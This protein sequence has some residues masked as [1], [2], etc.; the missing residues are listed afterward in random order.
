MRDVRDGEF[1]L[2]LS[3]PTSTVSVR[4]TILSLTAFKYMFLKDI[5]CFFGVSV[6]DEPSRTFSS[7]SLPLEPP[8]EYLSPSHFKF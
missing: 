1:Y 6:R 2:T 4:D 8:G 7:T 5:L 3:S